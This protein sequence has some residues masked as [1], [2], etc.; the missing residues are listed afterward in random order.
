MQRA[1][2]MKAAAVAMFGPGGGS[3][4]TNG[5]DAGAVPLLSGKRASVAQA[6]RDYNVVG[7]VSGAVFGAW[8]HCNAVCGTGFRFR[9]QRTTSCHPKRQVTVT[10]RKMPCL[11]PPTSQKLCTSGSS[12]H[13][14]VTVP[15]LSGS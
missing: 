5:S 7:C 10:M 14:K 15:P 11:A 6:L 4:S 3:D 12:Y 2:K 1:A 9:R 8:S 13:T